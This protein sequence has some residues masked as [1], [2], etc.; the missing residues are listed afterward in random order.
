MELHLHNRLLT[1]DVT[2]SGFLRHM[3]RTMV[4][5]LVEIWIG[6]KAAPVSRWAI[7]GRCRQCSGPLRA[8][9]GIVSDGSLLR[10]PA[11]LEKNLTSLFRSASL[12]ASVSPVNQITVFDI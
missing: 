10:A 6:K 1:I 4:G 5:T 3:V 8:G 9:P 11:E 12:L 7:V 2:G